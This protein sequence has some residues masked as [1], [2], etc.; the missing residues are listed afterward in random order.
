MPTTSNPSQL[1]H[2][3][4]CHD[5]VRGRTVLFAGTKGTYIPDGSTWEFDGVDWPQL[6]PNTSP[7]GLWPIETTYDLVRDRAVMFGGALGN[8]PVRYQGT[9]EWDGADWAQIAP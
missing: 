9:W 7:P 2:A 4:A 3:E 5:F 1:F 8:P 6:Q